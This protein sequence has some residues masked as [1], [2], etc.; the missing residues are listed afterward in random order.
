MSALKNEVLEVTFT[1][2]GRD[3]LRRVC[4]DQG[5][6]DS[7]LPSWAHLQPV[8]LLPDTHGSLKVAQASS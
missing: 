4:R 3:W 6:R 5:S 1:L 8:H 2:E 7:V